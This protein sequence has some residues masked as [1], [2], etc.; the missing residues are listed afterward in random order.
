MKQLL[1]LGAGL[2]GARHAQAIKA[3]T[4]CNLVGVIE[5]NQPISKRPYHLFFKYI[6][7]HNPVDGVII[8]TPANLKQAKE[9]S[10]V[11]QESGIASLVEEITDAIISAFKRLKLLLKR[12]KL[13]PP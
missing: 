5:P 10:Q 8:A 7:G 6:A 2:L 9:L 12:R 13:A 4:G 11:V 3:H 1:P